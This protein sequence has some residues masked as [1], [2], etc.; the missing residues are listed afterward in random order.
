MYR[1][2]RLMVVMALTGYGTTAFAQ[3]VKPKPKQTNE[4]A[5]VFLVAGQSN[6]G[7]CGVLSPEVHKAMGRDKKRPL[8]LGSTAKEIGLSTDAADYTRSYIWV[9]DEGFQRLDPQTNA[10][11]TSGYLNQK[12]HGME[13]P[14]I[15]ELQKRFP[16]NDIYVVKYGPGGTNLHHQWNPT[17]TDGLY[18]TFLGYYRD[19]IAQLNREYPEVRVVGLYWDQGESDG[20]KAGEYQKNLTQFI[21]AIR[22]D[23]GIPQLQVFIRKHI[24]NWPNIDT[25]IAAQKKVVAHDPRCHLLDIDVGDRGKNYGAWAYSPGNGHVSSK[26]FVALTNK[27]F[28]GPLRD[29][30]IESFDKASKASKRSKEVDFLARISYENVKRLRHPTQQKTPNWARKVFQE[31]VRV[32]RERAERNYRETGRWY[33]VKYE[34]GDCGSGVWWDEVAS[35]RVYVQLQGLLG[36]IEKLPNYSPENHKKAIEFWQGWQNEQTGLFHNPF[37]VDPANPDVERKTEGYNAAQYRRRPLHERV[38]QKYLPGILTALGSAPPYEVAEDRKLAEGDVASTV[39]GIEKSLLRGARGQTIGNQVTRQIWVVADHI[40]EGKTEFIPDYERLMALLI[41]R[42]DSETGLLGRPSF[43]D[44]I[45]SANNVKCNARIIGY[46]GLENYP[47]RNALA[48]SLADAFSESSVGNSGAIRNWSYL[49]TLVLQQT[50]HRSDDLYTAIENLVK[51]FAKGGSPGYCWMALSTAT[52]WL[53]WDLASLEAFKD[54]SVAACYNGV[55][56]PYR[57]VVGPFGRWVN[58]IPRK[59]QETYGHPGFSWDKH[60]LRARNAVHEKRKVI[61]IVPSTSEG[62]AKST[63]GEGR[64]I[65][66]QT[67]TL[68]DQKLRTPYLKAKWNG[69]HEIYLND[70]LVKQISGNFPDHCGLYIPQSA[71]ETLQEGRNVISVRATSPNREPEIELG[72][73]DWK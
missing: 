70:V 57:S 59:P 8:V 4:A 67:F 61:D 32:L 20:A 13:L 11:P 26:G 31:K 30:T 7:G 42:F 54:P 10:R 44:Y 34:N 6:A 56:R 27:L 40:D 64:V 48:D 28:D 39:R 62:W 69:G 3:E 71:R 5:I 65:L 35:H 53:H 18:A 50:D 72:L 14:V 23:T 63:D 58:L 37:F 1:A 17:R 38:T 12:W 22:R 9:P 66:K 15:R 16:E 24:F 43:G 60:S 2:F 47:Y 68:G 29:A 51:G 19:A 46:V 45:T 33:Y 36:G 41:R 73:I 25:I 55:N 52:A 21:A 49:S